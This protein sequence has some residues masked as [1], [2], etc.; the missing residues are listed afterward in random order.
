MENI[1]LLASIV[2]LSSSL[3]SLTTAI[4]TLKKVI[5]EDKKKNS[6]PTATDKSSK[7]N[8]Q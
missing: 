7:N 5:V 1:Q 6:Y 3:V 4:V 2:T 8:N